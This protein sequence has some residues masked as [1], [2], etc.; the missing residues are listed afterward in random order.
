M[1]TD[2]ARL[3]LLA[4]FL[5]LPAGADV[6]DSDRNYDPILIGVKDLTAGAAT[7]VILLPIAAGTGGGAVIEYTVFAS[8]A[9][10]HQARTG[11]VTVA[12]VNKAATETC[13]VYGV[14]GSFTVNPDQTK[15]GSSAGAISS[16]TLTYAWGVSTAGTNTCAVQ[17]N[18]ASSLTETVLRIYYRAAPIGSTVA[19]PQ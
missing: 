14:D 11:R 2:K 1:S 10:N 18:A 7:S 5:A 6:R 19:L 16:G 8:D 3:A 17:L 4:A 13:A 15:D 9:T 12:V